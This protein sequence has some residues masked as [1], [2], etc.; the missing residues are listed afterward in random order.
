MELSQSALYRAKEKAV[1]MIRSPKGSMDPIEGIIMFAIVAVLI[2]ILFPILAGVQASTPNIAVTSPLY[3][4]SQTAQT[5]IASGTGLIS[6]EALVV[7]A[8]VILATVMLLRKH[9]E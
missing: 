1:R 9:K 8:V 6:I 4:A 3:N 7:A 2:Y 5:T